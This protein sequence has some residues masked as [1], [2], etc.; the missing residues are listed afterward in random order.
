[1]R[2]GKYIRCGERFKYQEFIGYD[3][4][5]VKIRDD[6]GNVLEGKKFIKEGY[7]KGL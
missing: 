2:R 5:E 7:I 6:F 4:A 3:Y 1:M